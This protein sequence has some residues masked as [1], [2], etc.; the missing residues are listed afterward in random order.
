MK[1][2]RYYLEQGDYNYGLYYPMISIG[3]VLSLLIA[4]DWDKSFFW[5][6][7]VAVSLNLGWFLIVTLFNWI[8]QPRYVEI[9][10]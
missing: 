10:K 9:R 6:I 5:A 3:F 4:H 7:G 1:T 8:A 2:K